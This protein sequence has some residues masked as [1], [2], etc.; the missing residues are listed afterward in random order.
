MSFTEVTHI[1]PL[2]RYTF[3]FIRAKIHLP[4]KKK[5]LLLHPQ[6]KG[7]YQNNGKYSI[8]DAHHAARCHGGLC[9]PEMPPH[10][11]GL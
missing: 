6:T 8:P 4:F 10:G 5:I 1:S 9:S 7:E 3:S 11:R 2:Q